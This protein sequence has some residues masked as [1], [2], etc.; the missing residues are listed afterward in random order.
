MPHFVES[1]R[2][3]KE[4]RRAVLFVF[5]S[6]CDFVNDSMNMLYRGVK[7]SKTESMGGNSFFILKNCD[8]SSLQ[9]FFK[10]FGGNGK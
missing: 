6:F 8:K 4:C 7:L 3:V 5:K 10:Q 2:N 9:Y 1:L